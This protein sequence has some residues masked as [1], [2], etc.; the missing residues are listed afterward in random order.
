M[1]IDLAEEIQREIIQ[2]ETEYHDLQALNKNLNEKD[3]IIM[4]V[5]VRSLNANHAKLEILEN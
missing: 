2:A 5:N 1:D 3:S 4:Y